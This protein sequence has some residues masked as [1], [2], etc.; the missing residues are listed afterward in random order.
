MTFATCGVL[1]G[2][3]HELHEAYS[4]TETV[5]RTLPIP[6]MRHPTQT[7][8]QRVLGALEDRFMRKENQP[9]RIAIISHGVGEMHA[10][11]RR[12]LI[13]LKIGG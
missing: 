8:D 4:T 1:K 13:S 11:L 9:V 6:L 10:T 12:K 5:K 2:L 3:C 7:S